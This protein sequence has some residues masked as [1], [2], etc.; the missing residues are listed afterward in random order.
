MAG[1]FD[2]AA[3]TRAVVAELLCRERVA[4]EVVDSIV[5]ETV[6]R[7]LKKSVEA[8]AETVPV[9][10]PQV[11]AAFVHNMKDV[12]EVHRHPQMQGHAPPLAGLDFQGPVGGGSTIRVVALPGIGTRSVPRFACGCM[13]AKLRPPF[14]NKHSPVALF[15]A[16][17]T[18]EPKPGRDLRHDPRARQVATA[19]AQVPGVTRV[20][21]FG[22]RA[23]GDHAPGSDID[24]LVVGDRTSAVAD[25]CRRVAARAARNIY[26]A[27]PAVDVTVLATAHFDFMQHG[28]NHVAAYAAREGVTPMGDRYKPPKPPPDHL[29]EPRRREAMEQAANTRD[30]LL[31]LE[32]TNQRGISRPE[33]PFNWGRFLGRDAQGALEH[34]LKA[35]IAAHGRLYVRTHNLQDL[36][37]AARTCVPD[38]ALHS[39][40]AKLSRFAGGDVCENPD[41]DIE[42]D[43]MLLNVRNDVA[44]LFDICAHEAGFDPWTCRKTDY[45]RGA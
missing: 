25:A 20:L 38:L 36:L 42:P 34:A 15:P 21:L 26:T 8:V 31:F 24:L 16:T 22:S 33:S 19:V 5:P 10:F 37:Q 44:R 6:R 28:L 2:V 7:A 12:L 4:L 18:I 41:L 43:Q 32:E 11:R 30:H 27:P 29:P 13:S 17:R 14:G 9:H 40:L 3:R 35:V 1:L 23:R 45:Q 39:D